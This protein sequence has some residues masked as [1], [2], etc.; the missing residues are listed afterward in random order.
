MGRPIVGETGLI[1]DLSPLTELAIWLDKQNAASPSQFGQR[2]VTWNERATYEA[3]D[4]DVPLTGTYWTSVQS[5]RLA[6]VPRH[7]K[8]QRYIGR[9]FEPVKGKYGQ[10]YLV[11]SKTSGY[12]S[13]THKGSAQCG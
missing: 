4:Y 12:L 7:G 3:M 8:T 2:H 1:Q 10:P 13:V 6:A 5:D 11:G 9:D